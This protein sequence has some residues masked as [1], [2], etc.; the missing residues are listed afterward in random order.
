MSLSVRFLLALLLAGFAAIAS[1]H[2]V[3]P[4]YLEISET[5]PDAFDV[6]WKVP[7]RGEY[8]LSMYVRLPEKCTGTPAPGSFVA[9]A[10]V[11]RWRAHCPGGL[12]GEHIAIEG[13]NS[14]QTDV[15]VRLQR[16]DGT[17]QTV[18][19]T[20]EQTSF[21][22]LAV[23]GAWQVVK[24][25]FML[26]VEHILL[27][28]DHLLFVLALLFLVSNW[29]RLI[30]TVT[31]FTVAHSM[32]LAAATLGFVYVPQAPVEATIALSVVFVAGEILHVA[33]GKP[34]FTARAPWIVA[35]VFGLLHGFGF[36]GA[37][38]QI[39]LPQADIPL[40]LLFFNVGVEAGQ[41]L[42]ILAVV[43]L[44]SFVSRFLP[45]RAPTGYGPW[46][47]EQLI[48]VPVAYLVGSVAAF[49]VV[50]RVVGF[51]A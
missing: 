45:K 50:Q 30:V 44:L 25:Y 42:F 18:R 14:L 37:L 1:A 22:V 29:K 12:V 28:V 33:Q 49:W 3:R 31:A 38:R 47:A 24:A 19:L 36:A 5:G 2:E 8:R 34:S 51:W 11:E 9:G 27:G 4:G 41:V 13:L 7:A 39:G 15:L 26:G 43:A 35:F 10:Y 17:T 16:I 6:A 23:P 40:A 20:P 21:E 32:T 46:Q 48:R